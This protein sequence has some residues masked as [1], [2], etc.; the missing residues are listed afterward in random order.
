MTQA[1]PIDFW[2]SIGSLYTYLAVMRLA[3]VEART[4]AV[5][6]WRPFSIRAIMIEMDNIPAK[7]PVKLAYSWRDVERGRKNTDLRSARDH[8]TRSRTSI[9]PIASQSWVP[10]RA[11]VPITRGRPIGAG[12][13]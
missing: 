13:S 5:F 7:Q 4:G 8:P 10:P 9:S 12:S 6:R 1:S 2:F 3:E 11:G